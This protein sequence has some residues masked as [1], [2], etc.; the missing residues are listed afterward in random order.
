MPQVTV[1]IAQPAGLR[2][3]AEQSLQHRQ[4]DQLG[5]GQLGR[6]PDRRPPGGQGRGALQQ[7]VDRDVQCGGEGVQVGVHRASKGSTLGLQRRSWTPSSTLAAE[8]TCSHQG[9]DPLESII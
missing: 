3:E 8:A 4:A 7:L 5:V 1:G 6:D 9:S 2:T